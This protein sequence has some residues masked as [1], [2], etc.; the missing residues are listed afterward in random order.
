MPPKK[1]Y[2]D[3]RVKLSD[4]S[5]VSV[6]LGTDPKGSFTLEQ[7]REYAAALGFKDLSLAGKLTAKHK[8]QSDMWAKLKRFALQKR[9][10]YQHSNK[11]VIELTEEIV[12]AISERS[13]PWVF[14]APQN[15]AKRRAQQLKADLSSWQLDAPSFEVWA[16]MLMYDESVK[17]GGGGERFQRML[18]F[19]LVD[20]R[21]GGVSTY[22]NLYILPNGT[23][24][25]MRMVQPEDDTYWDASSS[26]F[27]YI[28]QNSSAWDRAKG[29]RI[30]YNLQH[31]GSSQDNAKGITSLVGHGESHEVTVSVRPGSK[32]DWLKKISVDIGR[33]NV[34]GTAV[35]QQFS[36]GVAVGNSS[37]QE[38]GSDIYRISIAE[39][40]G[41][42]LPFGNLRTATSA[43]PK[44]QLE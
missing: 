36:R 13:R 19:L 22:E 14:G 8:Q 4:K 35:N 17:G 26:Q 23:S 9:R 32:A 31:T 44:A 38:H 25:H 30:G 1:V 34:Q 41:G 16:S 11:T 43:F 33:Y 3:E 39:N 15:E 42:L 6:S 29:G 24:S 10:W 27:V 2:A 37:I 5:T 21:Y 40:L 28:S 7:L 12:R 20:G 18:H